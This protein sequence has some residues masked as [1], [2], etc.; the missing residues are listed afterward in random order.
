MTV[1]RA[2]R[3]QRSEAVE[4]D[5]KGR[6]QA[7][8]ARRILTLALAPGSDLD[9]A[10]LAQEFDLSRPPVREV[11]R[12]MAGEGYVELRP[13]RGARVSAMSHTT[14]RNFFLVAPMIYGAVTRLAA[15]NARA[16]Q[17]EAIRAVQAAFRR[18]VEGGSAEDRVFLNDRFHALTGEMADNPYVAP[19]LRRLLIDHAR[20]AT[21]FYHPETEGLAEELAAAAR[22][23]D[24]M[25]AA[26]EA[27]DEDAAEALAIAHWA[28]SRRRIEMFVQ[29][30]GL[31]ARLAPDP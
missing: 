3:G 12:H 2:I 23:H 22:Q 20:I 27:R 28:L 7:E 16:P 26:I 5:R 18:A 8:L 25:I 24:E 31:A 6:M 15:R 14:L 17:I 30:E 19:S 29:P 10:R 4:P 13:N 1:E 21:T 11:L 9:E